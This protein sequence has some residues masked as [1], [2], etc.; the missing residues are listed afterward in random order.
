MIAD[1]STLADLSAQSERDDVVI[2]ELLYRQ[3]WVRF[4]VSAMEALHVAPDVLMARYFHQALEVVGLP[5]SAEADRVSVVV[6]PV[7]V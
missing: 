4:D 2:I 6:N 3:Q 7:S 5:R 1:A